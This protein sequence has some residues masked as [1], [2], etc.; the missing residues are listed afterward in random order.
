MKNTRWILQIR[1]S[2]SGR[3]CLF[4]I[5]KLKP[6]IYVNHIFAVHCAVFFSII[7]LNFAFNWMFCTCCLSLWS[8]EMRAE[9]GAG[10]SI[11][12][13]EKVRNWR[14]LLCELLIIASVSLCFLQTLLTC[15]LV[16]GNKFEPKPN[17]FHKGDFKW[18]HAT[19]KDW[20]EFCWGKDWW[21]TR[22][23]SKLVLSTHKDKKFP[24]LPLASRQAFI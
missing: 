2:L 5:L 14:I 23:Q 24:S 8:G 4:K 20:W 21:F 12:K 16:G 1:M 7:T 6:N 15:L 18:K 22:A 10:G 17:R 11:P 13:G 3:K 19:F 9:W